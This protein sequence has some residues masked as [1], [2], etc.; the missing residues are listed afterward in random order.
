MTIRTY[1]ETRAQLHDLCSEAVKEIS[2]EIERARG[3]PLERFVV[4]E[5]ERSKADIVAL[6][7]KSFG[8]D[9]I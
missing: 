1:A 7:H 3:T 9:A 8:P 2:V 6:M 4:P 5:L